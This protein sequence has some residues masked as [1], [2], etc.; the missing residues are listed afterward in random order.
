MI[1]AHID[2]DTGDF[3]AFEDGFP[4]RSPRRRLFISARAMS[5]CC[6]FVSM[7][8]EKASDY[9]RFYFSRVRLSKSRHYRA[10]R[11]IKFR[12]ATQC[13]PLKT[14]HIISFPHCRELGAFLSTLQHTCNAVYRIFFLLDF[15]GF[16][17]RGCA[18]SRPVRRDRWRERRVK[19]V[20]S[21]MIFDIEMKFDSR[22]ESVL[23]QAV[24]LFDT[25]TTACKARSSAAIPSFS[26]AAFWPEDGTTFHCR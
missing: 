8:V 11:D 15:Q 18:C 24:G 16:R 2:I 14:S 7:L 10:A 12:K 19:R 20:E 25:T 5:R 3:S 6:R 26:H 23:A 22:G 17:Y 4:A 1:A 21:I 13:F 9:F